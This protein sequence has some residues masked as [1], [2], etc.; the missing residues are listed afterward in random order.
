M[1]LVRPFK[2]PVP[3]GRHE[4]IVPDETGHSTLTWEPE[5]ASVAEVR[6]TFNQI[7]KSG[8]AAYAES[9]TGE[10]SVIREFDETA[11]RIVVSSPLV[12]G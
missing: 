4:L 12:G 8:Y 9:A 2:T 7:M 3:P 5:T 6:E 1:S 10:L 11:S